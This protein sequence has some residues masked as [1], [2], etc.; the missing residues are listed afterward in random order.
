M[1]SIFAAHL[2]NHVDAGSTMDS[3]A[4]IKR[5]VGRSKELGYEAVAI[6]DHG[7]ISGWVDFEQECSKQNIKPVF[8]VEAYEKR[9]SKILDISNPQ[10]VKYYHSLFL[11]KNKEGAKFIQ[12]LVTYSY[13]LTNVYSKPRYDLDFLI[14]H[15][16]EIKGN[17][18]WSSA[19]ISGRMAKLLM[20]DKEEEALQYYNTMVDI[21]GKD[22]VYVELQ[23]HVNVERVNIARLKLIEFAK[24]YGC[25]LLAT[26]DIHYINK[27]EYIAREFLISRN[28]GQTIRMRKELN[29]IYPSE[30]YLK[31]K[32][33]MDELFKEVPEALLNTKR[34]VDKVERISFKGTYW[35]YPKIDIPEGYNSDTY[36]KKI[37]FEKFEE[38]YPVNTLSVEEKTS[39]TDRLNMELEVMSQLNASDYMLIDADFVSAA[40]KMMRVGPGRG[41]A[42]GSKVAEL[43]EI[44]SVD[45]MKY[46][47]FFERF[48][49]PK[50]VSMPD[51]DTD[52]A[53]DSRQKA[54]DYVVKKYGKDKVA[55]I[56]TVGTIGARMA[57][58]DVGAVLEIEPTLVDKVAKLIPMAPKVTIDLAL[59]KTKINKEGKEEQNSLY[60][61]ELF[62]MYNSNSECKKL[63]DNA[64]LIEGLVR[65]TGTHAA[66][67]II[68]DVPLEEMGALKEQ[69]GSE[70]SVFTFNMANV[71]YLKLIKFDFLGLRTLTV[72]EDAIQMIKKNKG[73]DVDI[74]S[75][76]IIE[77]KEIY[78][79]ISSGKTDGVFQLESAGMQSFMRELSPKNIEDIIIGIA[80]YR[81]GPLDKIPT[82]IK[83]K[84]DIS[85]IE[86]PP[87]ASKFLKPI[88][89]VT[90]GITVYQEEAMQIVRDLAGYDFGRSD[91]LR[92][93]MSK[94]KHEVMAYE[95]N[96]F[97]YG[98]AVCPHCNGTGR[99]ENGDE[100]SV[101]KGHSEIVAK[102]TEERIIIPGCIRNGISI[103]DANTIF[104]DLIEFANYAFNKSHAAAYAIIGIQTAYL[105]RYYPIEYWTA[106]LNSFLKDS[107]KIKKYMAVIKKQGI[108][109]HRP[110]IN[111]C[112]AKFTCDN[113]KIYMGLTAIENVGQGVVAA[114][115]ERERNGK[116]KNLQDLLSRVSLNRSEVESLIQTGAFDCFEDANRAQMLSQ[117]DKVMELSKKERNKKENG[118]F[119]L[120]DVC[121]GMEQIKQYK[122]PEMTE[123]PKMRLYLMEKEKSGFFLSGHPLDLPEYS[124][125][126]KKSNISTS[127]T[128]SIHD[129][130]RDIIMVGVVNIDEKTEGI[131]Y[132]KTG[133]RFASFRL[134]DKYGEIRVLAF[135]EVVDECKTTLFNNAIV[136]IRGKLSVDI[137]MYED[138]NGEV[139]EKRDIKIFLSSIS[140]VSALNERKK[141]F[142]KID[143]KNKKKMGVLKRIYERYPGYDTLICYNSIEKKQYKINSLINCNQKFISDLYNKLE[144]KADEVVVK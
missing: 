57:I 76:D 77:D 27:K 101:C 121:S 26:N 72:E 132:S 82:L 2:H 143:T 4:T 144:L 80:M 108:E 13:K 22:D 52:F 116:F 10:R 60:S 89:D 120:F 20:E 23:N 128:F 100:C 42:C 49:N 34:I 133:K 112:S 137:E 50:R 12:K 111:I 95:R 9:E 130:K 41:S 51:I 131:R 135:K 93:A 83:N 110:D 11:A 142:I 33:E 87:T 40:R 48:M 37:V 79:F 64:K 71:E 30:L 140:T 105:A 104:D 38:K 119:S 25:Q 61:P 73:I 129:N 1:E 19:C 118:Q 14:E 31:N 124:E 15:K 136:E 125:V 102:D 66:G 58:R 29:E 117:M 59:S 28:Y 16:D 115:E 99:E 141:V 78:K 122:Y 109:I 7:S 32:E 39:L 139:K 53:Y 18:I 88:L 46:G 69:E 47:L 67:V 94:K 21:F 114:I 3:A 8:G 107:P 97:I 127:D 123:Y 75:E 35:H 17:V 103:E 91:I 36:L 92:R 138:E 24:K 5:L 98:A 134:E 68:S 86:Y 55:Q 56:L 84:M 63:I 6:T 70:I 45:P 74:D 113:D 44:T 43:L 96:I 126:A 90:Y 81:P 65:Q 54:I 85:N 106:Y 62:E